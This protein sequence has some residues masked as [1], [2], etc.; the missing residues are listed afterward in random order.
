[1]TSAATLR[2]LDELLAGCLLALE[3]EA[4]AVSDQLAARGLG[5]PIEVAGGRLVDAAGSFL[6][7][8]RLPSPTHDVRPD[9][10]VRVVCEAGEASGFVSAV[11]RQEL[12]VRVAVGD[13][14]GQLPSIA[15]LEFDPTWLIRSLISRLEALRE[16]PERHNPDTI[17]RL[18]GRIPPVLGQMSPGRLDATSMNDAQRE[19]L[20]RILGSEVQLVWGPPGTGKTRLLGHAVAELAQAGSVL[21]VAVTNGAVDEAASRVAQALGDGAVRGNRIVRVGAELSRTGDPALSLE[22]ALERRVA[23]GRL[24][25]AIE[26]LEEEIG[27]GPP[28]HAPAMSHRARLSRL[29]AAA[30]DANDSEATAAAARLTGELQLQALLALREA[31]VVLT[32]FARLGLWEE[33]ATLPFES[34]VIDEASSAPLPYI[35]LAAS[36]ASGRTA[37]M[38][39][40]QQLPAV[41]V[42]RGEAASRWL[43]RDL[44]RE[45]GIVTDLDGELSLPTPRDRLCAMLEE[46]YRMAP[47]I[48]RIVGELFYDGRLKDAPELAA[49]PRLACPLLLVDS[50]RAQPEVIRAEGSRMNLVHVRLTLRLLEVLSSCGIADV[51]V[52]APYRLQVRKLQAAVRDQLGRAAPG[53]LEIATIHRFQGREKSV[54]LVDTVDAPPGASW[55]LNEARNPDLPRLVNVALSRARHALVLI[56]TVAGLRQTLPPTA[57]VNRLVSRLGEE[58]VSVSPAELEDVARLTALWSQAESSAAKANFRPNGSEQ[59]SNGVPS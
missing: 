33:F 2:E 50:E 36:R 58:G 28:S 27:L 37:A 53:G 21:V 17:L 51:A 38:G 4:L 3:E 24:A 32:T 54:L 8:W 11:S 10:A 39:D 40:F 6:Y 23:G 13:F 43:S 1:M 30:T 12:L 47:P 19:A 45:T 48:R 59:A 57:L 31:Q 18:F 26:L 15:T 16:K 52:V 55:F 49:R 22:A 14:L 9:D 42:S 35:A 29:V 56:A 44:F 46:Q 25:G 5:A 7:E 41:V 20:E 34:L